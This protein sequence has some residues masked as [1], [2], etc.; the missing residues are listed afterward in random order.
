MRQGWNTGHANSQSRL[1]A[2][3]IGIVSGK[4]R[5]RP[6]IIG[7]TDDSDEMMLRNVSL[8][9]KSDSDMM[10]LPGTSGSPA[11]VNASDVDPK[12]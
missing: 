6:V 2:H 9:S 8:C 7:G 1:I 5:P 4:S 3:L 10:S 11:T 12:N